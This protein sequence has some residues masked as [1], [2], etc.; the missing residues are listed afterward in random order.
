MS[1]PILSAFP[2][3][4]NAHMIADVARL[5]YLHHDWHVLD[6]TWGKGNWWKV[7]RPEKLT[8]HDLF[9][10]DGVDFRALPHPDGA[11]DAAAFDPPYKLNGR[12]TEAVDARYGVDV[13]ASWQ[14][15]HALIRDGMTECARVLAPKGYLLVKCQDQ[16]CGG[17]VRWQTDEFSAHG[18]SLG[19]AKVDRL[20]FLV[21]PRPQPARSRADGRE[22]RQDHARRNYSTL[23]VFQK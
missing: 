7:W 8:A 19:L 11:F 6:P 15:R 17:K 20:D 5:G 14:D 18:L 1:E 22:S 2:W 16:V 3:T 10:L 13:W 12:S 4:T 21:T 9:T 23:L